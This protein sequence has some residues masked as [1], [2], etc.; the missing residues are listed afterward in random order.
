[1]A[2]GMIGYRSLNQILPGSR[3]NLTENMSPVPVAK[4]ILH[5]KSVNDE[6]TFKFVE[7]LKS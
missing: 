4:Q 2:A 1:M 6:S 3:T 7:N 5:L